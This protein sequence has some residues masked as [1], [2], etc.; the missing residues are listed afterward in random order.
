MRE[1]QRMMGALPKRPPLSRLLD[2]GQLTETERNS[3][4]GEAERRVQE[5]LL[6]L[7]RAAHDLARTG[8]AS[9]DPAVARAVEELK[10]G[11]AEWQGGIAV[12]QALASP[13][14]RAAA[15]QWFKAQMNLDVPTPPGDVWG[16]S[17]RH[18][19]LMAIL[20]LVG[21]SAVGLYAY[22]IGRSLRL[23]ARLS[24]DDDRS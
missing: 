24:R 2:P 12:L 11:L 3:M 10:N 18:A 20:A 7:D 8:R 9:D 16:V 21:V 23:L 17:W 6:R 15:L 14:P 19:G 1:M 4:R 13:E 5:G 22:K